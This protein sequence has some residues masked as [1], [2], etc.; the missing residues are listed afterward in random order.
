MKVKSISIKITIYI[1]ISYNFRVSS[2]NS[3]QQPSGGPMPPNGSGN[4]MPGG[5]PLTPGMQGNAS[6]SNLNAPKFSGN[7]LI[8]SLFLNEDTNVL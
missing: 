7:E 2:A 3:S 5:G 1:K 4:D 6:D 8:N